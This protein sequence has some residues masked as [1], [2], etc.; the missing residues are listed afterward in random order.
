MTP[1]RALVLSGRGAKAAYEAG[2]V[3]SLSAAGGPYDVVVGTSMGAVNAALVAQNDVSAVHALWKDIVARNVLAPDPALMRAGTF[4]DAFSEWHDLPDDAKVSFIPRLTALWTDMTAAS[5][6]L[7]LRGAVDAAPMSELIAQFADFSALRRTFIVTA[8]D[9]ASRAASAFFW[10]S[11]AM[12]SRV[13]AFR[14]DAGVRTE[15]LSPANYAGVLAAASALP[16]AFSPKELFLG[17]SPMHVVGG[18]VAHASPIALALAAGADSVTIVLS[19][20]PA[21]PAASSPP[22]TLVD[23][24]C[25]YYDGMQQTILENDLEIASMT[26]ALLA[27]DS[28][29]PPALSRVAGKRKI[30]LQYVRPQSALPVSVLD[31]ADGGKIEDAFARGV[32]DGQHPQPL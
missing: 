27:D 12:S 18:T 32:A 9:V 28:V 15:A 19:D 14:A 21:V 16:G 31:F 4:F 10:F 6:L 29:S 20:A 8:A 1:I 24:L 26:N 2:V 7:A 30:A 23:L 22:N 5:P 11:P 25:T 3:A 17:T 13:A